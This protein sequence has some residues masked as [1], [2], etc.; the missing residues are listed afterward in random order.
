LLRTKS[1]FNLKKRSVLLYASRCARPVIDTVGSR[2][3]KVGTSDVVH[4]GTIDVIGTVHVSVFSIISVSYRENWGIVGLLQ[5]PACLQV[6]EAN[7]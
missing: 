5:Q 1:S 6:K 3:L 2:V 7:K 4:F